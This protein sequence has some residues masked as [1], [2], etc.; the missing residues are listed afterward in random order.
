MKTKLGI[1]FLCLMLAAG[2]ILIGN[3]TARPTVHAQVEQQTAAK[4]DEPQA[5]EPQDIVV[6]TCRPDD[7]ADEIHKL[8][9]LGHR[10]TSTDIQVVGDR[11]M[12][13]LFSETPESEEE[14]Q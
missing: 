14:K 10:V 3:L 9:K 8:N 2:F 7:L 4:A 12:I 11:V 5:I 6:V 13:V 1:I